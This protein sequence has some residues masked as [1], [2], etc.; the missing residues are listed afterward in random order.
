M[1]KQFRERRHCNPYSPYIFFLLELVIY[2]EL[3]YLIYLILGENN[4]T[5]IVIALVFLYQI[6]KSIKRLFYVKN[7][8]KSAESYRK[9]QKKVQEKLLKENMKK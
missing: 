7:R 1:I 6:V 4:L 8:C 3:A 9:F 2:G 5:Y